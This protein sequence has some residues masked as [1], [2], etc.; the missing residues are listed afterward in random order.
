[1]P[2]PGCAVPYRSGTVVPRCGRLAQRESASFTPKRSLVRSQYRPRRSQAMFHRRTWPL[3]CPYSSMSTGRAGSDLRFSIGAAPTGWNLP[4]HP[5]WS[6]E[7]GHSDR[8]R[9]STP[10]SA[11]PALLPLADSARGHPR[12][13]VFSEDRA[14]G[15]ARRVRVRPLTVMLLTEA[16]QA[17]ARPDRGTRMRSEPRR[18]VAP[19]RSHR[20]LAIDDRRNIASWA[21]LLAVDSRQARADHPARPRP[22]RDR[23]AEHQRHARRPALRAGRDHAGTLARPHPH[24]PPCGRRA[25]SW[26]KGQQAG[27][28]R[29]DGRAM[30]DLPAVHSPL[31]LNPDRA[32][33]GAKLSASCA[34][35][36][37]AASARGVPA[38]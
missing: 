30:T 25:G 24:L 26:V 18:A 4:S 16:T 31:A 14:L 10:G 21:D 33:S 29:A 1:V 8:G 34:T 2:V 17:Q 13:A 19:K 37:V 5:R 28:G 7:C 27:S 15:S 35:R 23:K 22:P 36:A 6:G 20:L 12:P 3:S 38:W 32:T 11:S 9:T